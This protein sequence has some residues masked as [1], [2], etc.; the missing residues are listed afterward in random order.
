MEVLHFITE[1]KLPLSPPTIA[2][3]PMQTLFR[4]LP[5]QPLRKPGVVSANRGTD[6][7]TVHS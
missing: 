1:A 4:Y 2:R 3:E 7:S 5:Q 6:E